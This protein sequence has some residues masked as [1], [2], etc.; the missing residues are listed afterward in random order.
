MSNKLV[1]WDETD[2]TLR[3][4]DPVRAT[5]VGLPAFKS[6]PVTPAAG[7]VNGEAFLNT[8]SGTAFVWNGNRWNP[9]VP[10]AIIS[11][12]DDTAVLADTTQAPGAYGASAATGNLFVMSAS[13]WRQVGTRV[14]P[15]V[16]ALLA[17]S[18]GD[19]QDA[20]ALDTGMAFVHA[21]GKWY[22]KTC[23]VMAEATILAN[24]TMPDGTLAVA[25]DTGHQFVRIGGNWVGS[26]V[27][28]FAT[29]AALLANTTTPNGVLAWGDDTMAPFIR[30]GGVWKSL[31][32]GPKVTTGTTAPSAPAEGDLWLDTSSES[33]TRGLNVRHGTDW[34]SFSAWS[35]QTNSALTPIPGYDNN[36][37]SDTAK[38][39]T[40]VGLVAKLDADKQIELYGKHRGEQYKLLATSK[41]NIVKIAEYDAKQSEGQYIGSGY[42][43]Y[44]RIEADFVWI[45]RSGNNTLMLCF[46]DKNGEIGDTGKTDWKGALIGDY[47]SGGA[48]EP[49]SGISKTIEGSSGKQWINIIT[50]LKDRASTVKVT[51]FNID[52]EWPVIKIHTIGMHHNGHVIMYDHIIYPESVNPVTTMRITGFQGEKGDFH[53]T[54]YG[55]R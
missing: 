35:L 46:S 26:P 21:Q 52:G 1:Y 13:G 14:Y 55:Y 10:S 3:V 54:V 2:H 34:L 24:T 7:L 51:I 45:P 16:T 47:G 41:P 23:W 36:A 11:Y 39:T 42:D 25:A 19:G 4:L 50:A 20:I 9:I 5:G 8:T 17:A 44:R 18:A 29:E 40:M 28:H 30:T 32:G 49:E 27:Q 53:G 6:G 43:A 33:V 15:T 37:P 48:K 12:P 22:P 31:A 38:P